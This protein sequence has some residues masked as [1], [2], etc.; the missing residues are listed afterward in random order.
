MVAAR[1]QETEHLVQLDGVLVLPHIDLQA[2]FFIHLADLELI[3][4][5]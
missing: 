5:L 4:V 1:C 2:D 3:V